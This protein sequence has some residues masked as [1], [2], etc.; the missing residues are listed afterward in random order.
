MKK[1]ALATL[2]AVSAGATIAWA[3]TPSQ[4]IAQRQGNF[5]QMGRSFKAIAD[6]LKKSSPSADVLRTQAHVLSQAA[7]RVGGYFPA[8]TGPEARVRTGALRVIWQRNADFLNI[9]RQLSGAAQNLDAAA[10]S[11]DVARIRS[12]MPAVGGACRTCHETFRAR[13]D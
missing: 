12:A 2:L 5:K 4:I 13:D 7:D 3:A 9:A 6:E 10:A 11:G 8:G 1:L